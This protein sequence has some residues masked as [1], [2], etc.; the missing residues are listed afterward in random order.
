MKRKKTFTKH[1]CSCHFC[2]GDSK[3]EIINKKYKEHKDWDEAMGELC[4][5]CNMPYNKYEI[6]FCSS[7]FHCCRDCKWSCGLFYGAAER[8]IEWCEDCKLLY[9]EGYEQWIK[10]NLPQK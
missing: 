2:V 1:S 6:G 4:R 9:K 3:E 10:E 7:N 8:L 5:T